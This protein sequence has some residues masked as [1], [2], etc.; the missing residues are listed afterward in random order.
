MTDP[1]ALAGRRHA[2]AYLSALESGDEAAAEGLLAQLDDRA[3]L[4]FLGAELT[5]LAR[6]AARSLSP[7]ERAQ[8]TGRQ[9]RLQLLRDAGK[10]STVG[11]RRWISASATETL[12]L[13]GRS[14]PDPADRL[15]ELRRGASA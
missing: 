5:G 8:A 13:L 6:R 12:G 1:R 2:H 3:D 15:A 4:V 10:G 9:M 11:L 14:I 7:A